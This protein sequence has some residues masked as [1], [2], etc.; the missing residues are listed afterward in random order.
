MWM[1]AAYMDL[2]K[3]NPLPSTCNVKNLIWIERLELDFTMKK[4]C[5]LHYY[6][7]SNPQISS[8]KR[9]ILPSKLKHPFFF[10]G[11]MMMVSTIDEDE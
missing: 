7:W 11:Q 3:W 4:L 10:R 8:L 9:C 2:N 5:S 6:S 1:R